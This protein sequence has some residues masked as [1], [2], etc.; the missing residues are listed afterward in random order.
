MAKTMAASLLDAST[1]GVLIVTDVASDADGDPA[2]DVAWQPSP[3][4]GAPTI[5]ARDLAEVLRRTASALDAEFLSD[6]A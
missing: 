4:N 1:I 3:I 6:P 5:G 2:Y